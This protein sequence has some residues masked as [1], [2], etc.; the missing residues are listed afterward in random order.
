MLLWQLWCVLN[1]SKIWYS[2]QKYNMDGEIVLYLSVSESGVMGRIFKIL[3]LRLRVHNKRVWISELWSTCRR[4]N[5]IGTSWICLIFSSWHKDSRHAEMSL[6]TRGTAF[7][8][9]GETVHI[10][11]RSAQ[12][13]PGL[14]LWHS[15]HYLSHITVGQMHPTLT[16]LEELSTIVLQYHAPAAPTMIGDP[17]IVVFVMGN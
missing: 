8:L 6:R 12:C 11:F 9:A 13:Q 16:L 10:S 5:L 4:W 3:L 7:S 17:T 14:L 15:A 2:D 1:L